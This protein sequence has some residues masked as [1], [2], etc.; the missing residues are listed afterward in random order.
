MKY[1]MG[2][3]S[4]H[5]AWI[6]IRAYSYINAFFQEFFME[7]GQTHALFQRKFFIAKIVTFYEVLQ[8]LMFIQKFPKV[9]A[10]AFASAVFPWA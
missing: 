10:S 5:T 7:R 1:C 3:S 6:I 2:M 4:K 8:S 9:S